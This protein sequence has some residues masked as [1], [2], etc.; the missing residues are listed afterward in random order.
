LVA[1]ISAKTAID[2]SLSNDHYTQLRGSKERCAHQEASTFRGLSVRGDP[3]WKLVRALARSWGS[4]YPYLADDIMQVASL[5]YLKMMHPDPPKALIRATINGALTR[6][7][8]EESTIRVPSST[9]GRADEETRFADV[10]KD[11][12]VHRVHRYYKRGTDLSFREI[13]ERL[14][15]DYFDWSVAELKMAGY[16]EEETA[17]ILNVSRRTISRVMLRLRVMYT[18]MLRNY[19]DM[20]GSF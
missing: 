17:E 7:T 16:T 18:D 11:A 14:H 6:F 9:Q 3:N 15:V 19:D 13:R 20:K 10:D 4:T 2:K 1:A 12:N 8:K 5:T